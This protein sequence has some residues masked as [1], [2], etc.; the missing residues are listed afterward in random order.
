MSDWVNIAAV[1]WARK[2]SCPPAEKLA[3]FVLAS[4][5]DEKW[6][7]FPCHAQLCADTGMARR[8]LQRALNSLQ[9]RGLLWRK[10]RYRRDGQG[11]RQTDV[12]T[13]AIGAAVVAA[14]FS[15]R[16]EAKVRL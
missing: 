3:L 10:A 4:R 6:S 14:D 1:A 7:C 13:L 9:Q 8:T 11:G 2:Q 5:A 16:D 12:Y 15:Q